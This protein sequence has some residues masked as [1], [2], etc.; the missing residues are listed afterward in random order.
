VAPTTTSPAM[1]RKLAV[2]VRPEQGLGFRL[3]GLDVRE[4]APGEE[5]GALRR[6]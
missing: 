6:W 3:A 1:R 5:A 2:A 4:V